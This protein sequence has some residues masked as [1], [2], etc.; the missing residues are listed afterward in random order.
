MTKFF[1]RLREKY[2]EDYRRAKQI[3]D[4]ARAASKASIE[5]VIRPSTA[6]LE[7]EPDRSLE[8]LRPGLLMKALSQIDIWQAY[9]VSAMKPSAETVEV[10][11]VTLARFAA[12]APNIVRLHSMFP[13]EFRQIM[14]DAAWAAATLACT[15][16]GA[17]INGKL[18]I[19]PTWKS[20]DWTAHDL[21]VEQWWGT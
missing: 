7:R 11:K 14:D 1:T 10:A 4:S 6:V 9:N 17:W 12:R 13:K 3:T 15:P 21:E 16:E 2:S 8:I 19:E 20:I 18:F 5:T